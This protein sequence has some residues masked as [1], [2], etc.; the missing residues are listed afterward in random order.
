M[1][2]FGCVGQMSVVADEG[3]GPKVTEKTEREVPL[4]LRQ[5]KK[6]RITKVDR[7]CG[8]SQEQFTNH[9]QTSINVNGQQLHFHA[10]FARTAREKSDVRLELHSKQAVIRYQLVP[11]SELARTLAAALTWKSPESDPHLGILRMLLGG[12]YTYKNAPEI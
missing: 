12:T 10:D 4:A 11:G 9:F 5:L 8:L 2:C 1:G 3:P 7:L 6:I